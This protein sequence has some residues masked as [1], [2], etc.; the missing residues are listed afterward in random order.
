M[1]NTVEYINM[2]PRYMVER[3]DAM[4]VAYIGL[5]ILEWHGMHNPLGLDGIKAHGIACHLAKRLGGVVMPP[6]FWG[7]Y[8][9]EFAEV[10]FDADFRTDFS[11]PENHFDH[12][13]HMSR[14][15][16]VEQSAYLKDG[17]R[18]KQ[19]G[20]WELWEKL[21]VRVM[22]QIE[23]L[24]FKAIVMIPGHYPSCAALDRAIER[25]INEGGQCRIL[26]LSELNFTDCD[27]TGDHAAA[28]ETSMMMA[29]NPELIDLDE[30]DSDQAKPNIGVIG[31]DPR[32]HASKELGERI[33]AKFTDL[34]TDFLVGSGL[35]TP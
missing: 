2:R 30:L 15:M 9:M 22:F 35:L 34:A 6:N 14:L 21:I 11:L 8:R 33:L 19:Y 18:S 27:Y 29:L 10:E 7:D 20:G 4:P 28:T 1:D 16:G 26:S 23:T 25:Y 3:R 24:G 5:G 17:E 13:V 12:T 32:T 31:L